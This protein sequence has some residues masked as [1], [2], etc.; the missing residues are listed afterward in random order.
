MRIYNLISYGGLIW[1]KYNGINV[2]V[3]SMNP[4][5]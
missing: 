2:D 4:R 5:Y 1:C 3:Y